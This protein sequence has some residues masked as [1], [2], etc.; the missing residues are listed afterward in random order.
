MN[1]QQHIDG[2]RFKLAES[3]IKADRFAGRCNLSPTEAKEYQDAM[4]ESIQ[5]ETDLFMYG[6][7]ME[8]PMM[9]D[10]SVRPW[11][12]SELRGEA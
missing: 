4:R 5:I 6:H 7:D 12:P 3:R 1:P 2:L 8:A 11:T 10:L 9:R